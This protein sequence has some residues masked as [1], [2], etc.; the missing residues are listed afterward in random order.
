VPGLPAWPVDSPLANELLRDYH[1]V[2]LGTGAYTAVDG[3]LP[4]QDLPGVHSA[5]PFLIANAHRVLSG[6]ASLSAQ[7]A[8]MLQLTGRRV[9]VLGGGDTAMDCVRTATRLGAAEVTCVYRR[10]EADMP[11]SR[12]EVSNAR[13]EGVR[14]LFNRQPLAIEGDSHASGVHLIETRPGAV[15]ASGRSQA[16]AIPGS[17]VCLSAEVVILA[18]GFR[19]SPAPWFSDFGLSL[20]ADGR[21]QTQG[22]TGNTNLRK[23]FA[24]GDNVRGAD[25]V[26]TAVLDGREAGNAIARQLREG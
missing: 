9:V 25:L 13:D 26:V 16:C 17:E 3:G 21:V 10:A 5:L 6:D 19:A 18:F 2:F 22:R 23:V 24:G 14:F 12:R 7:Q 15:D 11:G 4:G 20:G 8:G 1:A